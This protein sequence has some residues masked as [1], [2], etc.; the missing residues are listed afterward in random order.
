MELDRCD[1]SRD[2]DQPLDRSVVEIAVAD[3]VAGRGQH[4]TVDDLDLMVVRTDVDPPAGKLLHRMVS[5]VMADREAAG[6]RP[7]G[8]RQQLMPEADAQDGRAA[9]RRPL[10]QV[11]RRRNLP[12]HAGGV[13]GTRLEDH[14][15]RP[16][17]SHVGCGCVMWQHLDL[18]A[19]FGQGAKE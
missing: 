3:A 4:G 18:E 9:R 12:R 5:A 13:A 17:R 7:G 19:T 14:Q 6:G 16:G 2:V 15:V 1:P 11:S 8:E 10:S